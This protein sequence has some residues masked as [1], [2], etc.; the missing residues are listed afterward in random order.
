MSAVLF[1]VAVFAVAGVLGFFL[2][3][4][5]VVATGLAIA[6]AGGVGSA[7]VGSDPTR[8]GEFRGVALALLTL[9]TWLGYFGLWAL[10]AFVGRE[11]RGS[12]RASFL[13]R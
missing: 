1:L 9:T 3:L 7:V 4:R 2:R 10:G 6:V 8:G 12:K 13:T 5:W 11:V